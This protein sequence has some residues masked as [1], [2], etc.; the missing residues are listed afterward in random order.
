MSKTLQNKNNITTKNLLKRRIGIKLSILFIITNHLLEISPA[1][2]YRILTDN[3]N[4]F[5]ALIK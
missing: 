3:N 4:T 2:D 5:K 1:L